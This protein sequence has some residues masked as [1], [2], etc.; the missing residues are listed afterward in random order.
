M[1][2]RGFLRTLLGGAAAGLIIDPSELLKPQIYYSI[3]STLG[4]QSL[5][6]TFDRVMREN[7]MS[8]LVENMFAT[9]PLYEMLKKKGTTVIGGKLVVPIKEYREA[10]KANPFSWGITAAYT[11]KPYPEIARKLIV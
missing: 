5:Q 9:N 1:D 10:V 2:R 7:Y 4:L 8:V 6:T 3:P 11:T